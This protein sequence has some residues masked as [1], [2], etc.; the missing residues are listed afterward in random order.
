M[1]ATPSSNE[2]YHGRIQ[3]D[4]KIEVH[5]RGRI[6]GTIVAP[7]MMI[8]ESAYIQAECRTTDTGDGMEKQT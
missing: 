7:R 4:N 1:S 2:K 3:C 6:F 5:E 8:A